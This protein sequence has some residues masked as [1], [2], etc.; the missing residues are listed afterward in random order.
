[1]KNRE[2][3]GCSFLRRSMQGGNCMDKQ[4]NRNKENNQ[5]RGICLKNTERA[6]PAN[7]YNKRGNMETE[8]KKTN[9]LQ[10]GIR[11][12]NFSIRWLMCRDNKT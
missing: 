8:G 10:K 7:H 11:T 6:L 1:M 4:T 2:N 9:G 3:R 5:F 12:P